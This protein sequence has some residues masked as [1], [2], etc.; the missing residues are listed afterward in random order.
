MPAQRADQDG[1][2][3]YPLLSIY[4]GQVR[5]GGV[6]NY[7]GAEEI[8]VGGAVKEGQIL[9]QGDHRDKVLAALQK[10]GYGARRGN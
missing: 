3:G 9:L 6:I 8:F 4:Q 2:G 7:H 1:G 10:D 5:V